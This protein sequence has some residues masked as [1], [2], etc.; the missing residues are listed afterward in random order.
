MDCQE[1]KESIAKAPAKS[2]EVLDRIFMY[3]TTGDKV[4]PDFA[5]HLEGA[6][7]YQ[8][9]IEAIYRDESQKFTLLWAEC[10]KFK[11][12]NW[13][14]YFEP[15]MLVENVRMQT[16][17]VPIQFGSGVMLAP[18]GSRDNIAK[19]YVFESKAFNANAA[20]FVTSI[21]GTFTLLDH[22]FCGIYGLY[23]YRGSV[24]L[25]EWEVERERV[26]NFNWGR[27]DTL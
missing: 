27:A 14:A 8:D 11:R 26:S 1:L 18:T 17:G 9:F 22:E 4:K 23:K 19:V 24:I 7:S 2:R 13:L 25:E 10:A 21:G 16:D 3:T 5:A 15:K 20:E 6:K 12:R